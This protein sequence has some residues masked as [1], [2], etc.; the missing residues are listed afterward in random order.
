[1]LIRVTLHLHP[2]VLFVA[3]IIVIVVAVDSSLLGKKEG[4]FIGYY[5]YTRRC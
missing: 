1:M 4:S 3:V 5:V 2:H